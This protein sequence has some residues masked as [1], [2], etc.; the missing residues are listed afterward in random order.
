MRVTTARGMGQ[1]VGSV[2]PRVTSSLLELARELGFT[3]EQVHQIRIENPNSLQD[4]SHA[5][6]RHW[7]QRDHRPAA[8]RAAGGAGA[9]RTRT[10]H[11]AASRPRSGERTSG[12]GP[13]AV[14]KAPGHRRRARRGA[15]ASS[16]SL[17]SRAGA[18]PAPCFTRGSRGKGAVRARPPSPR[19]GVLPRGLRG[20]PSFPRWG[21]P[22]AHAVRPAGAR[23]RTAEGT[24]HA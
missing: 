1:G 12:V 5:L 19:P 11:T 14:R 10:G 24:R 8:G 15:P 16:S 18:H 4:Q 23:H 7:R 22:P 9:P 13:I 2:R 6:L 20:P 3:E 17:P 21:R